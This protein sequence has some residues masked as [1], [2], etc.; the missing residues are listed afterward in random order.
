MSAF[1]LRVLN[2]FLVSKDHF[3]SP[4][5]YDELSVL[6][7]AISSHEENMVISHEGDPKWRQAVLANTQSLLALRSGFTVL[8]SPFWVFV[9]QK[10]TVFNFV[11]I[12]AISILCTGNCCVFR[13]LQ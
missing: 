8:M 2:F 12:A 11:K 3:T 10:Y 7:D 13:C 6:Y 5:E 1:L 9:Q 4:D